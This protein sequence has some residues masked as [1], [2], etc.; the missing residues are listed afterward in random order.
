MNKAVYPVKGGMEDWA[1]AGSWDKD[2]QVKCKPGTHGGYDASR[3]Q[4]DDATLRCAMILVETAD[5]KHPVEA[6]LG[7]R[8]GVLQH[9][10][11]G[12]GHVPRNLRAAL[13]VLD[14]VEAY[15]HVTSL[16]GKRLGRKPV[17]TGWTDG[18]HGLVVAGDRPV[19][20]FTDVASSLLPS[21]ADRFTVP[22]TFD[23]G[24]G[25]NVAAAGAFL[26]RVDSYSM[27][28][29]LALG[30][31][32]FGTPSVLG[33]VSKTPAAMGASEFKKHMSGV[34]L[35][36]FR[37]MQGTLT[38]L[39]LA[40]DGIV[41]ATGD[42]VMS[43]EASSRIV[44]RAKVQGSGGV[45]GKHSFPTRWGRVSGKPE[46][47]SDVDLGKA[48]FRERFALNVSGPLP[49]VPRESCAMYLYAVVP[50]A[51]V[52]PDA[53]HKRS[54]VTPP[55]PPQLHM[56]RARGNGAYSAKVDVPARMTPEGKA[57]TW[58]VHGQYQAVGA[59]LFVGVL[60]GD[61]GLDDVGGCLMQFTDP[62][63][64]RAHPPTGQGSAV[65]TTIPDSTDKPGQPGSTSS[66]APVGPGAEAG[67]TPPSSSNAG[68]S[69]HSSPGLIG[70][71][72][73]GGIIAIAAVVSVLWW[74][75]GAAG[76]RYA[77]AA[78]SVGH[79]VA[80]AANEGSTTQRSGHAPAWSRV[81]AAHAAASVSPPLG[82]ANGHASLAG[83]APLGR[84]DDE[85]RGSGEW[86][87]G[88]HQRQESG[89]VGGATAPLS[90]DTDLQGVVAAL[91][92]EA[93]S[94]RW[95]DDA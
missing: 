30:A 93:A 87:R 15:V 74:R 19:K 84:L 80:A 58:E 63:R 85:A 10:G 31:R 82:P 6:S 41:S 64:P 16:F 25:W 51:V 36:W 42:R 55:L 3:T 92:S 21:T 65:N 68:S 72:I 34:D 23:V 66:T 45:G 73:L 76:R 32:G 89:E 13:A 49:A 86:G 22:L 75:Q 2:A 26:L 28:T 29:T 54:D 17:L 95:A 77:A 37:F 47:E 56:S 8:M 69:P 79:P 52:D 90:D 4:Y 9:E 71:S 1:Y 46:V 70:G 60:R 57:V 5:A 94:G 62:A 35:E 83:L 48:A 67:E 81:P 43:G 61:L 24:G 14:T 50:W 38:E 20:F 12:D 59:P 44:G 11:P 39:G 27:Q 91:E 88:R 78:A 40:G 53:A 18:V 33:G 7:T